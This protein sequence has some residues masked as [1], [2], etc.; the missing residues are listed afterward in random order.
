MWGNLQ[1]G[2]LYLVFVGIELFKDGDVVK[3]ISPGVVE[4][5]FDGRIFREDDDIDIVF[6]EEVSKPDRSV[7][8]M[9]CIVKSSKS[10]GRTADFRK[11]IKFINERNNLDDN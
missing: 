5:C 1:P 2:T 4:S 6:C 9:Q 3:C 7:Q 8:D 11:Y 10:Y